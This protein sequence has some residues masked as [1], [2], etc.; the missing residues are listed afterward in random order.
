MAVFFAAGAY[1]VQDESAL[2]LD[3]VTYKGDLLLDDC[4][5]RL[6]D[7]VKGRGQVY[8]LSESMD[9]VL[10]LIAT[11][12]LPL[13]LHASF[14]SEQARLLTKAIMGDDDEYDE[15]SEDECECV[16]ECEYECRGEDEDDKG[17]VWEHVRY[18]PDDEELEPSPRGECARCDMQCYAD[19]TV[20]CPCSDDDATTCPPVGARGEGN[21]LVPCPRIALAGILVTI[22]RGLGGRGAGH[23]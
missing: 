15:D 17:E 14:T 9:A 3:L 6:A 10:A 12:T 22:F 19:V 1:E 4:P 11:P 5:K 8:R 23:V 18:D 7:R 2:R 16:R 13:L 20:R 21:N